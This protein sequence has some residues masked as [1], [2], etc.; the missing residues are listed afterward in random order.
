MQRTPQSYIRP[1]ANAPAMMDREHLMKANRIVPDLNQKWQQ[2]RQQMQM[3]LENAWS[4]LE[5]Q[6]GV[7]G[8]RNA[9]VLY[10]EIVRTDRVISFLDRALVHLDD[11]ERGT[12]HM[13]G[14]PIQPASS[15]TAA[16]PGQVDTADSPRREAGDTEIHVPD[17]HRSERGNY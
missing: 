13:E 12:H 3:R 10:K 11:I 1:E 6:G 5:G 8:R 15:H 4:K 7:S 9:P 17:P 2:R 16:M 14:L